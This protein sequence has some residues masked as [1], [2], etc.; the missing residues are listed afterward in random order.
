[1]PKRNLPEFYYDEKRQQYRK[2]ITLPDGRKKD[3]YA[4]DK[5]TLRRKVAELRRDIEE[6]G[7][8]AENPTL[9]EYAIQWCARRLPGLSEARKSDYRNAIN[10]H[11]LPGLDGNK[12]LREISTADIDLFMASKADIS[13]SLH[14]KITSAL[15]QMFAAAVRDGKLRTSPADHVRAGGKRATEKVPLSEG[16]QAALIKAVDGTVA[17]PF[18]MLGLYAGLR[19][20]EILGL[21]WDCVALSGPAPYLSVERTCTHVSNSAVV[22]STLKTK[23]AKRKIPLP[24]PLLYCLRSWRIQNPY[25]YVVPNSKGGPRSRQSFRR[26]WEIVENRTAG[27]NYRW[28]REKGHN[29]PVQRTLGEKVTNHAI[30]CTLD[31]HC[32][33]HQLRHTYIT[34]L[35]ASGLDIKKIQYLAGHANVQMTLN[36]YA[37]VVDNRPEDLFDDVCMAFGT[38]NVPP[39]STP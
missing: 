14:G 35:C 20:E 23:A 15:K 36:I 32:T 10:N 26:L 4:K 13:S 31:F 33:P 37:H 34:N 16:Q 28:D 8:D 29:M 7:Y 17:L 1:M 21:Q 19:K 38:Q 30:V 5:A 3:I 39:I 9:A 2:R 27:T 22:T 12:R 18:V 25:D 6:Y 11:I 24:P